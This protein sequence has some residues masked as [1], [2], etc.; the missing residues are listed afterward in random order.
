MRLVDVKHKLWVLDHVH[1][2][3]Q[4]EGV[5]LPCVDYVRISDLEAVSFLIQEV[6][7][8]LDCHRNRVCPWCVTNR[9]L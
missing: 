7:Q 3:P 8:I 4:G 5:I 9:N 1:P 6:K 2:E